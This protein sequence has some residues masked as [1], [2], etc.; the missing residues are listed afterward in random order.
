MI[1][2]LKQ[3]LAWAQHHMKQLADKGRTDKAFVTSDWVWVKLQAYRQSSVQHRN[4]HKLGPN[5]FG[6]FQVADKVGKVAYRLHLL[7][8]AQI[9]ST[10][11]VS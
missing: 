7:S 2:H 3:N 6:P 8:T 5:Y 11:H 10:I 4:N 1:T 9:H